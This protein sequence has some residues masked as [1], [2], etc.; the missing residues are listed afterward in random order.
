MWQTKK[1]R[2][3]FASAVFDGRHIFGL[4]EGILV[5]LDAASGDRVWKQGRYNHGQILLAGDHIIV[6]SE[7]GYVAQVA[8]NA[9]QF[10]E[11]A[12]VQAL[13]QRTWTHPVVIDDLLLTRNDREVVCY[14]LFK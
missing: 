10:R 5:C 14:R 12:R 11:L 3:K 13:N 8:A 4:D 2:S 9:T 1:L 6:Q 7:D